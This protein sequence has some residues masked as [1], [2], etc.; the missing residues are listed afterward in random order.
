VYTQFPV[1][2]PI[3]QKYG[4]TSVGSSE[5]IKSIAA[6]IARQV[7]AGH[8]KLAVVVSA[9]SG[10]TNRL[11]ELMRQVNPN[12][13]GPAYDMAVAAGEQ[14]SVA[15]MA[16]AIEAEGL[17]AAP[18]LAYKLGIFTDQ[19]HAKARI[20]TI[21]TDGIKEAWRVGAVAVVAGFQGVTPN[22]AL[23]TLGRGGSDTSAVAM[24]V[25]LKAAFCEINTD[26]DGVFTADPR[27]VPKARLIERMDYETALEMASLG[28][29]VL[30]PRCVEL[31][32]KWKM[33]IVVRNT[34]TPDEH[35][36][37]VIMQSSDTTPIEALL[38][39]GVTLDRHVARITIEGLRKDSSVI[40]EVFDKLG[41][42]GV[43]VDIIVHDRPDASAASE[44]R[45]GF[46]V[47]KADL[48][49]ARKAINAL[50]V[51]KGYK[52]VRAEAEGG[53]SKVS[54]VGVGMHSYSGVAGRTFAALTRQD[55]EIHMISTSEIKISCVV[56]EKDADRATR[57]LHDEF[58]KE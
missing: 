53:V 3:V 21:N 36:R 12:A 35:Q 22:L 52:G 6:R 41:E 50:V 58:I 5:R 20:Q 7:R 48:E 13:S 15:L 4:G 25:A 11:V 19:L 2:S 33:P 28:S 38:V 57:A 45:L 31:G 55:I 10:E 18:F 37:T 40:T 46:T 34:F 39:S 24:A 16:A 23:T 29:K 32:A 1:G 43:N 26:V 27:I 54:V 51:D 42:L 56:N 49:T 47:A 44:M 8:D 14:V 30:H 9:Q 17:M